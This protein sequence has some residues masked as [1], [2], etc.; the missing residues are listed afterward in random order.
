MF[1]TLTLDELAVELGRGQKTEVSHDLL[2][3]LLAQTKHRDDG[4]ETVVIDLSDPEG[5]YALPPGQIRETLASY[6][7][8][9]TQFFHTNVNNA[10]SRGVLDKAR[11]HIEKIA[12]DGETN[13]TFV[14]SY[15]HD[16]MG[17]ELTDPTISS[18]YAQVIGRRIESFLEHR[19]DLATAEIEEGI[20]NADQAGNVYG[21]SGD[22]GKGK[23]TVLAK[24]ARRVSGQTI[25]QSAFPDSV[26][27]IH[28]VQTT[29]LDLTLVDNAHEM[30]IDT[31]R[32]L[33]DPNGITVYAGTPVPRTE[34][35]VTRETH[36]NLNGR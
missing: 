17:R 5:L 13:H 35:G 28:K 7:G 1:D 18:T 31:L 6:A 19:Q 36:Y 8:K 29:G 30:S 4:V 16:L 2:R 33:M 23:T 11:G 20:M 27:S 12:R 26:F 15:D 21:I 32:A 22:K 9:P 25:P 24:I 14:T 10:L 3:G 34:L